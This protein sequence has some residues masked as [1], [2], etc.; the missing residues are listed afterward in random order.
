M[1]RDRACEAS[2]RDA[3]TL[4]TTQLQLSTANSKLHEA[5][6]RERSQDTLARER[7]LEAKRVRERGRSVGVVAVCKCFLLV[8]LLLYSWRFLLTTGLGAATT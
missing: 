2:A 5:I 8:Y 4:R 6:L 7:A 1:D 3:A